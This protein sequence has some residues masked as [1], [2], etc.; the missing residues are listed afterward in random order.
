MST[1]TFGAIGD[2]V[3]LVALWAAV[4]LRWVPR[5]ARI[6]LAVAAFVCAWTLSYVLIKLQF[7]KWTALLAAAA[8]FISLVLLVVAAQM[9]L[10]QDDGGDDR[11]DDGGGLDKPPPDRP[12]DGGDPADP[13][14]WPDFER[15]LARYQAERTRVALVGK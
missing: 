9:S 2:G 10:P 1:V 4:P 12:I 5:R 6:P 13:A 7:P 11:D 14:W 8:V 3:A 15:D